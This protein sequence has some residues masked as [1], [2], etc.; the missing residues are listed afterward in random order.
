M[1]LLV[2][3]TILMQGIVYSDVIHNK[4]GIIVNM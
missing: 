2:I 4:T 1:V 3:L